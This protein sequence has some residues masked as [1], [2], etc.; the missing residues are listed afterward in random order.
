MH[1]QVITG[2]GENIANISVSAD[3]DIYSVDKGCESDIDCVD[4]VSNIESSKLLSEPTP[5]GKAK[6]RI[7]GLVAMNIGNE[8]F[9]ADYL[10]IIRFPEK[11]VGKVMKYAEYD[12]SIKVHNVFDT[13]N[14]I[15]KI[16]A[17]T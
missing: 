11:L 3:V 5:D 8:T 6:I 7:L 13:A 9:A 10:H 4:E 17:H 1:L 2:E 12:T 14:S 16:I 15:M